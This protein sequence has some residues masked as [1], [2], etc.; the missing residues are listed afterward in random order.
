[1][2]CNIFG[3]AAGEMWHWS[4]LGVKGCTKRPCRTTIKAQFPPRRP[5]SNGPALQLAM[6]P[7][8]TLLFSIWTFISLLQLSIVTST[9]MSIITR[10]WA[11]QN[12]SSG[13]ANS[14]SSIDTMKRNKTDY[15]TAV[16]GPETQHAG[17]QW[18]QGFS[19]A[20]AIWLPLCRQWSW[21]SQWVRSNPGISLGR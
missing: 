1:M 18:S 17:S 6:L 16:I 19:W 4:L 21:M 10:H 11:V 12:R 14:F 7:E 15:T 5:A 3:E 20:A 8:V 13:Q 2:W 9:G